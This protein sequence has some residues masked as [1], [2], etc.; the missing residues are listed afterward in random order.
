MK[1]TTAA[2]TPSRR[3][4]IG[5]MT[6]AVSAALFAGNAAG[7]ATAAP[8]VSQ[9]QM[10]HLPGGDIHVIASGVPSA[11]AVV[12][13]HGL[14]GSTA[15]W[16]PVMPALQNRYVVRIDLL[17]HGES[18]KPDS[19]YGMAEQASRVAKVLDRLGVRH[20]TVVGHSTGGY[21]AT[22]LAEQRHDLVTALALID[23]GSRLDAFT[24]NGP[25]SE[26]LFNPAIGQPLWPLLPDAAIRYALSSAFTRDVPVPERIVAD[27]RGMTYQS[28]TATSNA[29]DAYLRDRPEPDRLVD[30]GL[31]TM[32]I[33][34]S[35]DKRW[36][37]A[38][39]QDYRRVPNVRIESLDCG[40]TPM[41]E[42]PGA[43]GALIRDFAGHY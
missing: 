10:V 40:H 37:A 9:E 13:L 11:D 43:T 36:P 21:V 15:W 8:D 14:A 41:I 32:V 20:A 38:S 31:P 2:G 19:G 28:L 42:D 33:Y 24:G 25:A 17:G 1:E 26:L 6:A 16:D 7:F 30:L 29:S 18:A 5:L 4:R 3:R 35:K 23:T 34:G 27:V 12:L 22:S 39:F